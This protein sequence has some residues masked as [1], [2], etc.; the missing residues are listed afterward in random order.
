MKNRK[1][2]FAIIAIVLSIGTNTVTADR[3]VFYSATTGLPDSSWQ[4]VSN[5]SYQETCQHHVFARSGVLHLIDGA[6]LRGNSLGYRRYLPVRS[7]QVITV[8]FRC[9]VLEGQSHFDDGRA[10]FEVWLLY[11]SC[12]ADLSIGPFS[13]SALDPADP[14]LLFLNIPFEGTEWHTYSYTLTPTELMWSA[15]G[16]CLARTDVENSIVENELGRINMMI[17]SAAANVE[18]SYLSVDTVTIISVDVKPGRSPAPINPQS[19]AVIPVAVLTTPSF[20]AATVD[21][22]TVTF[23]PAETAP[24]RSALRDID[25][26]GDT[27]LMLYFRTRSSG[28]RAGDMEVTLKAKTFSGSDLVGTDAIR[29]FPS[30]GGNWTENPAQAQ[31][32]I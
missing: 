16:V 22:G 28:I 11:G 25:S 27:D 1:P 14:D 20:D 32:G 29:T 23:G 4:F 30:T 5:G 10:P 7:N 26:D 13:L 9:R 24:I 2:V 17:T 19:A 18:L 21:P 3:L 6:L 8:E 31:L 15:D 12:R